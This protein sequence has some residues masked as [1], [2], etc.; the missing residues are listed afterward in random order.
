MA[1]YMEGD[2]VLIKGLGVDIIEIKRIEKAVERSE[3]FTAR[4]FT[5]GERDYCQNRKGSG[6]SLA[7]RFAAK[8]AVAKV[9][10]TGIGAIN[11]TDIEVVG[12]HKGKPEIR[13]H[14]A[15]ASLAEELGLSYFALSMSHSREYAIAFVIAY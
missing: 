1:F 3:K 7:A 14:N 2:L 15:A 9:L 12:G 13:L 6:A 4:V 5:A 11:W 10:G 8:E